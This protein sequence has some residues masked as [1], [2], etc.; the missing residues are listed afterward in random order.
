MRREREKSRPVQELED[1]YPVKFSRRDKKERLVLIPNV[2]HAF[3]RVMSA[4]RSSCL[5][6]AW[7][8]SSMSSSASVLPSLRSRS[9]SVALDT[10]DGAGSR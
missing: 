5:F 9:L 6:S 1:P 10:S 4:T 7:P 8:P 3:C 2:S